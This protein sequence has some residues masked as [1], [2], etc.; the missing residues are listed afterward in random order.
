MISVQRVIQ[1]DRAL[2]HRLALPE[3]APFART[4]AL[5]LAHSGDS[6]LWLLIVSLSVLAVRTTHGDIGWHLLAG[7]IFS[8]ITTTILKWVFR[9]HRPSRISRGF[10]STIDRH[11]LPSGHASRAACIVVILAPLTNTYG[12]ILLSLWAVSVGLAR[13]ALRVHFVLDVV[14]G[15]ATGLAV[16]F[17]VCT[18]TH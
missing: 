18:I 5:V 17:L 12:L 6:P 1:Y 4:L 16:G 8:G 11:S 15:W 7:I 14:S 10:Y 2:S 13:V 9:R 3:N